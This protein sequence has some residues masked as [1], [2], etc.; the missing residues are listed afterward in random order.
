LNGILE[1][2]KLLGDSLDDEHDNNIDKFKLLY[3]RINEIDKIY[4]DKLHD[5]SL[6]NNYDIILVDDA[7]KEVSNDDLIISPAIYIF[8]DIFN[9][10][11]DVYY[12]ECVE[13][14]ISGLDTD[15]DDEY[16]EDAIKEI[17]NNIIKF[18]KLSVVFK[19]KK[20]KDIVE[21]MTE[22]LSEYY[23]N[24]IQNMKE[25][26]DISLKYFKELLNIGYSNLNDLIDPLIHNKDTVNH[27]TYDIIEFINILNNYKIVDDEDSRN[28]YLEII[29]NIYRQ[30]YNGNITMK[31]IPSG[32]L[33]LYVYIIYLFW[34]NRTPKNNMEQKIKFLAHKNMVKY[35]NNDYDYEPYFDDEISSYMLE[36]FID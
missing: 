18:N 34:N 7:E 33:T 27:T 1:N 3:N 21:L 26:F 14:Y 36:Q 24:M 16:N 10:Y 2:S 30:L 6:Y 11:I 32:M 22:K 35:I 19:S 28:I 9:T 12:E 13:F 15:S 25:S 31:H 4:G 17:Q 29:Y 20:C 8:N 23:V 5:K